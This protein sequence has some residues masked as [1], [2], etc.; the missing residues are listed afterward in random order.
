MF[1]PFRRRARHTFCCDGVTYET[2]LGQLNFVYWADIHGVF[3]YVNKQR[4][5][6]EHDMNECSGKHR[7]SLRRKR[8]TGVQHT[9][10]PLT[11]ADVHTCHVR[12]NDSVVDVHDMSVF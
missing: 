2:T 10:R 5:E 7:A 6:I 4:S 1:D 12:V 11:R 3:D 9:R 8:A